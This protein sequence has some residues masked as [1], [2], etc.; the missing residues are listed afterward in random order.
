MQWLDAAHLPSGRTLGSPTPPGGAPCSSW[1]PC[2]RTRCSWTSGAAGSHGARSEAVGRSAAGQLQLDVTEPGAQ[3][4]KAGRRLMPSGPPPDR[5]RSCSK[6]T[7]RSL[8]PRSRTPSGPTPCNRPP[9]STRTTRGR[10]PFSW[11]PRSTEFRQVKTHSAG[12]RA[13][14]PPQTT[15]PP[16]GQTSC[17][18]TQRSKTP[19]SRPRLPT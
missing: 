8:T 11:A 2:C 5:S 10:T 7:P 18:Q 12:P 9:R 19:C 14:R 15:R 3:Q 13:A 4:L 16:G 6:R 17:S 1:T